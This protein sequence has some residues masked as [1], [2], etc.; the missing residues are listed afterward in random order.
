MWDELWIDCRAATMRAGADTAYGA[1]DDAAI[2]ID[3]G[4]IA[5]A[6]PRADLPGKPDAL[7][8]M[9]IACDGAWVTPGLIDCHTHAVFGGDRVGEFEARLEGASYEEIARAGG[10][11]RST[12][13][14][15]REASEESLA[16]AALSRLETLRR[17]GVTTVEIKSGY[18]LDVETELKMLRAA[19]EAARRAGLHLERTFLGLHAL[20][21]D[22]ADDRAGYVDL[23]CQEAL[24]KACEAGLVDAVDAFCERIGFTAAEVRR[25]FETAKAL[26]L[27]VRLH[28]EQ[29]SDQGGAA[30]AAEFGALSADHLEFASEDGIRAMAGAGVAA[31]LLPGAFYA[32]K[33]TRKPPVALLREHGVRIAIATDLNPGSSPLVSPTLAMN[34][35][36][37]LFGLTPEEALAGM[38]RNAAAA[39]GIA[40]E[41]GTIETGKRADLALWRISRPAEIA[42]WIGLPGP[43]RLY[44]AGR[45]MTAEGTG[46]KP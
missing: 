19:G 46:R 41:A 36:C 35:A 39:L 34:M 43:D 12:V 13:T 37:T 32:L 10:G 4:R 5:W 1:I 9:V 28:A 45:N 15:T 3:R 2:A 6:G 30:L 24:P 31:V 11:I 38:T 27:P 18:G 20:P 17:G 42:Y 7:A 25:V 16:E 29:L 8:A 44:I 26:G 22:Y 33:E 40:G 14:A 23:V 21:E